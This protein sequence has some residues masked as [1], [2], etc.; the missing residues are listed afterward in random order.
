MLQ[1]FA[2][3]LEAKG[4]ALELAWEVKDVHGKELGKGLRGGLTP[5]GHSL[6]LS[7][8]EQTDL[9][10]YNSSGTRLAGINSSGIGSLLPGIYKPLDEPHVNS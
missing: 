3:G 4:E 6:A 1:K 7:F 10:V 2:V 8:S 9:E 5:H